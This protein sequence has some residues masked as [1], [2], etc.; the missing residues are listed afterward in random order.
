MWWRDDD[1]ARLSLLMAYL[2]TRTPDW[3]RARIRLIV[4]L[5]SEPD[6]EERAAE[7]AEMLVQVRIK[8]SVEFVFG[9]A[10]DDLVARSEGSD[11]VLI[12]MI[13]KGTSL[14]EGLTGRTSRTSP[15][16][17]RSSQP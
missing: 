16:A 4:P 10:L 7:L 1:T 2:A 12:P 11:L 8:A 5:A 13:L 15:I 3:K 14:R 6:R 9:G 17:S